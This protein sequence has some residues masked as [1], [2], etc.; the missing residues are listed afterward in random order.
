[1]I[2]SVI[3][4]AYNAVDTI[5]ETIQSVRSQLGV[6]LEHIIID[7]GSK[8][9]SREIIESYEDDLACWISEPDK[10]IYDAMNKG[11]SRAT[12]DVIGFLNA[13]DTYKENTVLQRISRELLTTGYDACFGDLIYVASDNISKTLRHYDSSYFT[14]QSIASGIMPAHPTLYV[15]RHVFEKYGGFDTSYK[16]AGDFDF[17]AKVFGRHKIS[18]SYIPAVLVIMKM[19]GVSTRSWKSNIQLNNEIVRSCKSNGI[20]TNLLRIYLKY[21]RKLLQLFRRSK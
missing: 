1:M 11:I 8:D 20:Q 7:G 3:T 2:I 19:G 10:G 4:V 21:P 5:E 12:G 17:V 13:D 14:P 9:G 15:R 18:Y 6:E 16:I